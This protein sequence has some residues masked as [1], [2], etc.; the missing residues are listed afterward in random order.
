[1]CH[2]LNCGKQFTTKRNPATVYA[3]SEACR[4]AFNNRRMVRGAEL[5]DLFMS[6]RYEREY[7]KDNQIWGK[8]CAL[9]RMFHDEDTASRDGRRSWQKAQRVIERQPAAFVT[10]LQG[11]RR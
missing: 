7:A 6:L 10:V 2:C 9:A 1:M 11:S 8:M 3:C 5:Y 4:K